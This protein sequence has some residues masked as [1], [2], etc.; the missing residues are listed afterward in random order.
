MEVSLGRKSASDE[1]QDRAAEIRETE[2]EKE[3]ASPVHPGPSLRAGVPIQAAEVPLGAREGADGPRAETDAH[4]G[5]NL[6]PEPQVQEQEEDRGEGG[7][8]EG[9]R[10]D[11]RADRPEF[12]ISLAAPVQSL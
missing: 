10:A 12:L 6:V 2:G 9:K 8:R 5:E 11:E 1:F 4:P 7:G 3:T